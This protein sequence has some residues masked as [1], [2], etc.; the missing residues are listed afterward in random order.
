[1]GWNPSG[2]AQLG[3]DNVVRFSDAE[4]FLRELSGN[5]GRGRAF[6][7]TK[8]RF[9]LQA[10]LAVRI[11]APGVAWAVNAQAIVVF[12][13]DGFVGLEFDDFESTVLPKLDMLGE[14]AARSKN[15]PSEAPGERTVIAPNPI[16]EPSGP[17]EASSIDE[18]ALKHGVAEVCIDDDERTGEMFIRPDIAQAL[19]ARHASDGSEVRDTRDG[20]PFDF[21]DTSENSY[22]SV[23]AHGGDESDA[24]HDEPLPAPRIATRRD[25]TIR[26]ASG[27]EDRTSASDATD[28]LEQG[29]L[30]AQRSDVR[31]P[32]RAR[33]T[34]SG[35]RLEHVEASTMRLE[36]ERP[37]DDGASGTI[38]IH[39]FDESRDGPQ[40]ADPAERGTTDKGAANE[41][42]APQ[43]PLFGLE[44]LEDKAR[45][46]L[47]S[48]ANGIVRA[49]DTAT[50][51]GLYLAE[52]RHGHLTVYGGPDGTIGQ[53]VKIKIAGPRV[54]GLDARITARVGAW[55]TLEIA[56]AAPL[57]EVLRDAEDAWSRALEPLRSAATPGVTELGVSES[58]AAR[59]TADLVPRLESVAPDGRTAPEVDRP[60]VQRTTEDLPPS[61]AAWIDTGDLVVEDRA[62]APIP[63]PTSAPLPATAQAA[64]ERMTRM[65]DE[66][67]REPGTTPQDAPARSDGA[68]ALA[69]SDEDAGPP[70]VAK[71]SGEVV[72]FARAKD[73]RHELDTNLRNGGLFVESPPIPL[74]TK[75]SLKVS[76]GGVLTSI[77]ID[78]EVV[79]A[80]GG[81]VGF[82][83]NAGEAKSL[84]ERALE[85]LPGPG[86]K[87]QPATID[88]APQ[89]VRQAPHESSAV[90]PPF[91][92]RITKPLNLGELL[93]F[94]SR[95]AKN[96]SDLTQAPVISVIEFISRQGAKGVLV[97]KSGEAKATIY[98]HDGSVAYV[99]AQPFDEATSL[100]RILVQTKRINDT[101]L[102][103]GLDRAKQQKRSLGRVLVSL[104][105]ITK[106]V[107]GEAL[108]EQVREKLEVMMSWKEGTFDWSGWREPP[109][110]AD[111]VLTKGPSILGRYMR[112]SYEHLGAADLDAMFQKSVGR[113]V[114]HRDNVEPIATAA[115]YQQKDL[116]FIELSLN[117]ERTISDAVTGSPIGRLAS[118]RL[119]AVGLGIGMLAFKDGKPVPVTNVVA[120]RSKSEKENPAMAQL[121]RDLKERLHLFKGMN[122]FEVLG[123]HW[124]AHHRAY[125]AA[126]E[127][128]KSEYKLDRG[129]Y[130]DASPEVLDLAREILRVL[131][132]AYL[133]L[134]DEKERVNYRKQ[135]FDKTERQYSADMLVKQ[136]EVALMRGDRVGAIEALETA[137]ELDPSPRNRSLLAQARE[138]KA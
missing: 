36:A 10:T 107:L 47:R 60:E 85:A 106:K 43:I 22:E 77:A 102:R 26:A 95:R 79:F 78:A 89:I 130:R 127:K 23:R 29:A 114:I 13:R 98:F 125:R 15:G 6:V 137:A 5:L 55:V 37:Q 135:L 34:P 128:A 99:E 84:L 101:A 49:A 9:D 104:G 42:P 66:K 59:V 126:Y 119:I 122:Y 113:I 20:R 136:G 80:A 62:P 30:A 8:R 12:S 56:S 87:E 38:D 58:N 67:P 71:L 112:N 103:E 108:R 17:G 86:A 63:S 57:E 68:S 7:R 100:G 50:L 97:L 93:D 110:D 138:G 25:E 51:L 75:R 131:E 88:I 35:S 134:S 115:G 133:T 54:V 41:P 74:R 4:H 69:G 124:S 27:M 82:S 45:P 70:R 83:I 3:A 28:D 123:V 48:T 121:K 94:Q 11:E 24:T 116:R 120:A 33:R 64:P 53:E 76:I 44:H 18:L 96:T 31:P 40:H 73:L 132:T 72:A 129:A 118:L 91:S 16:R 21:G 111:L 1:V 14:E 117:G 2:P 81:R 39:V 52:V 61:K 109:G 90:V 32:L 65:A 105:S 92:G 19:I 46:I